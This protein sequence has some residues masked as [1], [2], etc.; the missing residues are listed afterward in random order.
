M[1]SI[2]AAFVPG[3]VI[4][5]L[6]AFW[7]S[8]RASS[9]E[10]AAQINDLLK[11]I[12]DLENL[13]TEYW[14]AK[15]NGPDLRVMEVKIRGLTFV[16]AAFEEQAD[17]LFRGNK[18][19]YIKSLDKLFIAATGGTFETVDRKQDFVRAVDVKQCSA[20]IISLCRKARQGSAGMGAFYWLVMQKMRVSFLCVSWPFRW[21]LSR[22]MKP[23]ISTDK[24]DES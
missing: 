9:S 20:E 23:L 19:R 14:S 7:Q 17:F 13:A 16:I 24:G 1:S 3:F 21:F 10:V 12:K 18:D 4:F 11:E 8:W 22:R 2:L 6:G 5:A 15:R